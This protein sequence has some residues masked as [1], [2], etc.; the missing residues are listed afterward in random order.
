MMEKPGSLAGITN[1]AKP[2]RRRGW[3]SR[4]RI[5]ADQPI[6]LDDHFDAPLVQRVNDLDVFLERMLN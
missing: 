1:S 6:V 2:A 3:L 4:I 5:G